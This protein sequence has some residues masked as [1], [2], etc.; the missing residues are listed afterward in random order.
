MTDRGTHLRALC[1]GTARTFLTASIALL[2]LPGCAT[3]QRAD[4]MDTERTLAAAGFRMKLADTPERLSQIEGLPQRELTLAPAGSELR[5]VYADANYC[6]CLFV[7]TE[8]AY[9]R[10]QKLALEKQIEM[11]WGYWG[12]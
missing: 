2:A 11:N 5:F 4:A 6:K 7:G 10:Y 9:D 12:E 3:L 8:D 1:T